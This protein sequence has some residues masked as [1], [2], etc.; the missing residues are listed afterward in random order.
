MRCEARPIGKMAIPLGRAALPS[1]I[2]TPPLEWMGH[3]MGKTAHLWEVED[4]PPEE[5]DF[6]A[7]GPWFS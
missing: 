4:S 5:D 6:P 3:P 2:V 1:A 7:R